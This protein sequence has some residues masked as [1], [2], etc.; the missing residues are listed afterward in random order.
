MLDS[1][2]DIVLSLSLVA[3]NVALIPSI[4][5][6][7]KPRMT[8]SVLTALFLIPQIIV[9][10]SI[11]LW[12]SFTMAVINSVLWATLAVQRYRQVH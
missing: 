4:T 7:Q 12:Y 3:F 1:W 8:T 5:G 10:A 11:G 2:Q 6:K 9:F